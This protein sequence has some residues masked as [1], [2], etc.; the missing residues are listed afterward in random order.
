MSLI[1][2]A[3]FDTFDHAAR[4]ADALTNA[5]IGPDDMHTFFVNPPG[6]HSRLSFGGDRMADPEAGNAPAGALSG[7]AI[8]AVVGAIVGS[9]IGFSL[10]NAVLPVIVGAGVGAYV[11][12]MMGGVTRLG[13]KNEDTRPSSTESAQLGASEE[14]DAEIRPSGVM[15]A[16]RVDPGQQQRIADLLRSAGGVEVER[17]HGRW[18]G[19]QWRDFDPLDAPD[20]ES[21]PGD[22]PPHR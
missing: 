11:G 13:R 6:A 8:L 12:A 18:E 9:L 21:R 2:A 10:N 4:A 20:V 19:G 16:V 5:G 15:L 1:V 17:A 7:A 14:A 22:V 3:R